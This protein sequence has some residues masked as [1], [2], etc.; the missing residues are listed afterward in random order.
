MGI[1]VGGK[2]KTTSEMM[3]ETETEEDKVDWGN[4]PVQNDLKRTDF[5]TTF[6]AG[7]LFDAIEVSISYG[8]GLTN[9]CPDKDA[10]YTTKNR[11]LGISVAYK[12]G[13]KK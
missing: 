4:D 7:A 1:G 12:I 5:G 9:I 13:L 3:G 2:M 6:G 11:V 10:G 8:L